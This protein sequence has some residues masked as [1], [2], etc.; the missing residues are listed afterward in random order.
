MM[1]LGHN[2]VFVERQENDDGSERF[3]VTVVDSE[4]EEFK[5]DSETYELALDLAYSRM[6]GYPH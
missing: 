1:Q 2:Q 5:A 6:L 4:G 3:F